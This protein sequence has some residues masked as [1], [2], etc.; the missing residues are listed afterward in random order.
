MV[1][2]KLLSGSFLGGLPHRTLPINH[3]KE[4]LR[5]LWVVNQ[6]ILE[7]IDPSF[8]TNITYEWSDI[9]IP[10]AMTARVRRSITHRPL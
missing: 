1:T 8:L 7:G 3:R 5:S 2:R 6:T 4:L 9:A 10:G